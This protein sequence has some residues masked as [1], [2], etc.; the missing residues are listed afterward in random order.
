VETIMP[1]RCTFIAAVVASAV[2]AGAAQSETI[3]LSTYVNETDIRYQGFVKFAE[4]VAEKTDG[5]VTV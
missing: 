1:A 2:M 5:R 4:L 3:R